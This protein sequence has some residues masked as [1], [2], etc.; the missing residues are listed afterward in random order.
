MRAS[1]K[2]QRNVWKRDRSTVG[3]KNI[4]RKGVQAG[5]EEKWQR[6]KFARDALQ[7]QGEFRARIQ[8]REWRAARA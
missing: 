2:L 7:F 1:K 3:F 5:R 8:K 4:K 6:Q